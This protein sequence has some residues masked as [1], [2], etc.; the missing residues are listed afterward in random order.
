MREIIF[1]GYDL[2]NKQWYYGSYLKRIL[3]QV[4]PMGDELKPE[5]VEHWI[6][7][8]GFADWGM[9][10]RLKVAQHID[11]KS[12]GQYTGLKD[13]NNKE[14]YEGDIVKVHYF[15]DNY[16][17]E[18]YGAFED[19]ETTTGLIKINEYGIVLVTEKYEENLFDLLN[20][21]YKNQ[22]DEVKVIGNVYENPELLETKNER[23][24]NNYKG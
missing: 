21:Y 16:D 11:E 3:R 9:E 13:E 14:I 7:F 6:I 5:D 23:N 24:N 10:K 18:T 19:E 12:V 15:F 1:R 2:D 8:N 22:L 20:C 4:A 17:S